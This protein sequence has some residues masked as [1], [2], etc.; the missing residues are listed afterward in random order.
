MRK[1]A[2]ISDGT[3]DIPID[4][5][6][7]YNIHIIPIFVVFETKKFA[8]YSDYGD[9]SKE[10]FY[11]RLRTCDELPTTAI[12]SQNHFISAFKAA[13]KEAES[14]IGIFLSEKLSAHFVEARRIAATLKDIDITVV[15]SRA[16]AIPL[17]LTVLE[18]AI[19]AHEGKS[20]EEILTR[21]EE[22]LIP[23]NQMVVVLDTL[24]N[25]YRGG[26]LG[27]IQ[28][29]LGQSLK[30]KPILCYDKDGSVGSRG[31]IRGDREE[32]IKRFK[33]MVPFAVKHA[34]TDNI[35]IWHSEYMEPAKEL[36]EI[37]ERHNDKGKK[38]RIVNAG[39]VVGTH[40]GEKTIGVVY[41]GPYDENWLKMKEE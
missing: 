7:K 27:K 25:L 33:F 26:R 19:M 15:D 24:E 35:F 18:A 32:I 38:I 12:A 23:Q 21:L 9:L 16:S 5:V 14:V 6:E 8:I 22:E 37:M 11:K 10:E 20:K 17:G 4:L 36:L 41:I 30:I 39:P 34:I 29:F 2:I 40:V 1:V 13:A 28:K 31:K 3:S